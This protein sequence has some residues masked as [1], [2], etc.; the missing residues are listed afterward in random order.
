MAGSLLFL[1][2]G[3]PF[4]SVLGRILGWSF[5]LVVLTLVL[6]LV[7]RISDHRPLWLAMVFATVYVGS[8]TVIS[9]VQSAT[10]LGQSEAIINSSLRVEL[11][12]TPDIF[13]VV[14]DGYPASTEFREETS[15]RG[16]GPAVYDDLESLGFTVFRSAWSAYPTTNASL[17]SMLNMAYVLEDGAVIDTATKRELYASVGGD[18]RFSNALRANG[19][20]TTLIESGWSG[21]SCGAVDTC[22]SAPFLDESVFLLFESSPFGQDVLRRYGY[23]FTAGAQHSMDW[24]LDNTEAINRNG[25][26]DFVFGH[27]TAPHPPFFLDKEC[28]VS[29]AEERSGVVF[30]RSEVTLDSRASFFDEQ[31]TCI[32]SFILA[33]GDLVDDETMMIF[34]ADHGTDSRN[35]LILSS[36]DWGPDEIDERMR[37]F[38]AMSDA[39]CDYRDGV[40]LPEVLAMLLECIS[41][42]DQEPVEQRMFVGEAFATGTNHGVEELSPDRVRQFVDS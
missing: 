9:A 28:D 6:V 19:Y 18:N 30:T 11:T 13:L 15:A 39:G 20:S 14:L 34:V 42:V 40:V 31:A 12:R 41:G 21:L 38:L 33:L 22:V 5:F 10:S 26:P 3:A 32:D 1:V 36:T 27:V 17:P 4:T 23:S 37:V 2:A 7:S 35:Q 25:I 24:L 29:F 16:S 8:G